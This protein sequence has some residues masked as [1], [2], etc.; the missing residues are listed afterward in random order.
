MDY[1]TL[2]NVIPFFKNTPIC[3]YASKVYA[4]VYVHMY[5]S[6]QN[7]RCNQNE[8]YNQNVKGSSLWVEGQLENVFLFC[9][10]SEL[11]TMGM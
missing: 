1:K 6:N 10:F 9:V 7:E 8:R 4:Y 3:I 11:S 5:K 2:W